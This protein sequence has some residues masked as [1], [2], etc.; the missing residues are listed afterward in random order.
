MKKKKLKEKLREKAQKMKQNLK[1]PGMLS[2]D[3][4]GVRRLVRPDFFSLHRGYE[5]TPESV[6]YDGIW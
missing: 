3:S 6:N 5:N 1:N 2:L 4:T